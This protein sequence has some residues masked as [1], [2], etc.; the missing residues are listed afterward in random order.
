[1]KKLSWKLAANPPVILADSSFTHASNVSAVALVSKWFL[2]QTADRLCPTLFNFKLLTFSCPQTCFIVTFQDGKHWFTQPH[3]HNYLVFQHKQRD[4]QNFF[5]DRWWITKYTRRYLI[6]SSSLS[7][8]RCKQYSRCII[9]W[10]N[11][12]RNILIEV[13]DSETW[14]IVR[15]NKMPIGQVY[16]L[17]G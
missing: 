14:S 6:P 13:H 12:L 4:S 15:P 1:M 8:L 11:L 2:S 16:W 7:T 5:L 3:H 9:I 10:S 17:A